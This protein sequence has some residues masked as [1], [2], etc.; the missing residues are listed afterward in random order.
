MIDFIKEV[1]TK[2][3]VSSISVNDI[4]VWPF[5][6][7]SYYSQYGRSY[8]FDVLNNNNSNKIK[9]TFSK[10][11]RVRNIFYGFWNLFKKYD[12]IVFSDTF[13][14]RLLN[15]KYIDKIAESLIYELGEKRVLLIE[16]PVNGLHFKRSK[17]SIKN[18]ISLDLFHILCHLH[19]LPER[20]IINNEAILKQINTKYQLEINYH[21]LISRFFRYAR[22][23]NL[24]YKIYKPKAIFINCYYSLIHQ[25]AICAA[26]K[27]GI[28][29][30]EL[31]HGIINN[32]HSAYNIFT[33]LDKSFFPDYLLAFG[34]YVKNVFNEGNY[35]IKKENVLPVGSMYLDYI[36]Y[37][38]KSSKGNVQIFINFR[39]KYK[40]IVT[41]SSQWTIESKLIKFIKK[42]ASLSEDI[43]YIFVP[44]DIN[45]NYSNVNFPGNIIILK[46]LD[47][48][49][50]TRETNFHS[51][52]YS[53]CASEAPAIGVPNILININNQA[54]MYYS[55]LLTNRD[56]TRFVDT[57]KEFV[58]T[59]LT[60]HT[61]TKREIMSLHNGFYKE[62]HKK[63][64]RHALQ[65]IGIL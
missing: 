43:L 52:V 58:N 38:Y 14:K 49:Q 50:I 60:W 63:N 22:W 1:E 17:I 45:K 9:T 61:K 42:S 41:V 53:T 33:Y 59:I 40:K 5:L 10:L 2:Y 48:Y 51:T 19:L 39:K 34:D 32:K 13:E 3:N 8:R 37:K 7:V 21:M 65:G 62:N 23:F 57:E 35:F 29:T 36:N 24:F 25:A 12:Y 47:V 26:K 44:R 55:N 64:L 6:R 56:V 16:N 28:K 30:I 20:L 4:Q 46:H 54:K 18:I 27:M 31:Q 15:G 11:K